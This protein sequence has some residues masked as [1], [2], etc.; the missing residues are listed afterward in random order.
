[1]NPAILNSQFVSVAIPI[2]LAIGL[3]S[4]WNNKRLD[5][6]KDA[7]SERFAEVNRRFDQVFKR[8]DTI[9]ATL[10]THGEKIAILEDRSSP[11]V[12]R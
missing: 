6:F 1:M 10:K 2:V 5:D 3:S 7:M 9:D 4:W 11:I 12:R 8:L